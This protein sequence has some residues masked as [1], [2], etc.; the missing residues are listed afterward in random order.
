M[1]NQSS[2]MGEYSIKRNA[3]NDNLYQINKY[4]TSR[5]KKLEEKYY[6]EIQMTIEMLSDVYSEARGGKNEIFLQNEMQMKL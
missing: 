2:K 5:I 1:K 6:K 4:D 3:N